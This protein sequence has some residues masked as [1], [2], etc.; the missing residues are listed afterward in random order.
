[1]KAINWLVASQIPGLL[2]FGY[3]PSGIL[4]RGFSYSPASL[5]GLESLVAMEIHNAINQNFPLENLTLTWQ[6]YGQNWTCS[7]NSQ[8]YNS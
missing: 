2:R 3:D 4:D 6:N 7:P 8:L 5:G 1:V